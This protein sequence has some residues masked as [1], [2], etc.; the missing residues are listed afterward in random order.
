[1]V[2]VSEYVVKLQWYEVVSILVIGLLVTGSGFQIQQYGVP[3]VLQP[4]DEAVNGSR[5][6][7]S[8]EQA[9][10]MNSVYDRRDLE[11]SWCVDVDGERVAEIVHPKNSSTTETSVSSS[12]TEPHL[13]GTV[14]THPNGGAIPSHA[15]RVGNMRYMCIL[16]G[17]ILVEEG[18]KPQELDCYLNK[19]GSRLDEIEVL[20]SPN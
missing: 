12:C 10:E 11:W 7:F 14:H 4:E 16:N 17:E 1:M 13:D 15:D 18:I 8:L 9:E 6:V 2:L 19:E 5:L 20:L 3:D